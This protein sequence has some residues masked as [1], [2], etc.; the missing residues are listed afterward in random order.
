M[1][2]LQVIMNSFAFGSAVARATIAFT[3]VTRKMAEISRVDLQ[4]QQKKGPKKVHLTCCCGTDTTW[5]AWTTRR[6]RGPRTKH[7][8]TS[9]MLRWNDFQKLLRLP[10]FMNS[11]LA[12]IS[13]GTV[14]GRARRRMETSLPKTASH[15]WAAQQLNSRRRRGYLCRQERPV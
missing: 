7:P 14:V 5:C 12:F 1:L 2:P 13:T 10:L 11:S 8:Y 15:S 9:I 6:T 4:A 3:A